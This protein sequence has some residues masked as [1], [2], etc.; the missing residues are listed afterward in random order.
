MG[1]PTEEHRP[2]FV[3]TNQEHP[4][5]AQALMRLFDEL[6][7]YDADVAGK[8]LEPVAKPWQKRTGRGNF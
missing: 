6:D 2:M 7:E 5:R 1:V 8:P 4:N 3:Q